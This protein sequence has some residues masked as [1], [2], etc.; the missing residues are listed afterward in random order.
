MGHMV[1][2]RVLAILLGCGLAAAFAGEATAHGRPIYPWCA[3]YNATGGIVE[4]LYSEIA[5]CRASVSGV[6]G[7]CY[8]N[9]QFVEALP[10][11]RVP[12]ANRNPRH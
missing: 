6:G 5:Q 3:F 4:C 8:Q 2:K 10:P 1:S 9:P 7:F 12:H 11:R